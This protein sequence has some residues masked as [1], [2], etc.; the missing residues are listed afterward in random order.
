[1]GRCPHCDRENP[2]DAR[3]CNYCGKS[4]DPSADS[5]LTDSSESPSTI[6]CPKCS[7]QNYAHATF[8]SRC[9]SDLRSP[10]ERICW[11]CKGK[12][13]IYDY[14]CPNCHSTNSSSYDDVGHLRK[15]E[16]SS[17]IVAGIVLIISGLLA[18]LN[19]IAMALALSEASTLGI[20]VRFQ[21]CSGIETLFGL[22][23]ITAGILSLGKKERSWPLVL[24][25]SIIALISIGPLFISSILGLIAL[26][27]VATSKDA[28]RE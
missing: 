23:V 17:P 7:H 5:D 24:I 14:E 20:D 22:I 26:L 8:C 10:T 2:G 16:S 1:M 11:N 18:L 27:I 28:Y 3:F 15:E 21:C 25:G 6:K 9:G 12:M 19:G 4:M 13:S